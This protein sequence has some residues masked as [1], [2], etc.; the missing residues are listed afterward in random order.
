[1]LKIEDV[2]IKFD[3]KIILSQANFYANDSTLTI[4]K[5]QSGIGKSTFLKALM[6]EYNCQY[7]YGN[8]N[9]SLL[10]T[11]EKDQ[12]IY[13]K[14]SFVQQIPL[15]LQ[16]MTIKEH[17]S[18]LE[19]MKKKRNEE[20]EQKLNILKLLNKYP[21][22]LS[23][24]EKTKVAIYLGI[25]KEPDILILDEPTASLDVDS[26]N[27][28]I[29]LLKDYAHS[30]HIV[31]ATSHDNKLVKNADIIY[32][33]KDTKL[34][35]SSDIEFKPKDIVLL[36]E[37]KPYFNIKQGH[38]FFRIS[39]LIFI[40]ISMIISIYGFHILT[41]YNQ[42][43][44]N[45]LNSMSSLDILVYKQKYQ[46]DHYSYEGFEYPF[47]E[48][49]TQSLQTLKN[50][51]H[52]SWHYDCAYYNMTIYDNYIDLKN[53]ADNP[54]KV[55]LYINNHSFFEDKDI[56]YYSLHSYNDEIDYSNQLE[57]NFNTK[58][59][60]LTWDLYHS[61]NEN[62]VFD[63]TKDTLSLKFILLIPT[64]NASNISEMIINEESYVKVNHINSTVK[65]IT[66]PIAGILKEDSYLYNVEPGQA[67][68]IANS[69]L[70]KYIEEY[71]AIY[72]RTAYYTLDNNI[73]KIY[74]DEVPNNISSNHIYQ[75]IVESPWQPNSYIVTVDSIENVEEVAQELK[76][77]GFCVV[78]E[79]VDS[80]AFQVLN[81]DNQ[82]IL[83]TFMIVIFVIIYAFYI[84]LKLLI[85][86][87][88]DEDR[89]YL[90]NL[91]FN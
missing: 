8:I 90:K 34:I 70:E 38:S 57:Y 5:G 89:D 58:G 87:E 53:E 41:G 81:K 7:Y 66:V 72:P 68:Y 59:L 49:E 30:G 69:V 39:M 28:I 79:Y 36:K 10:N 55:S 20:L 54:S 71:K 25:I 76:D 62:I 16:S 6:F 2:S 18:M 4:I 78:N 91:G 80:D 63:E 43:Y 86:K 11:K 15:F 50:V 31:I 85:M 19:K 14:I 1:M 46:N 73:E 51:S 24:G 82:I 75:H 21:K 33:I 44:Q 3:H 45:I 88:E 56:G 84:Y 64:Y 27:I 37:K 13:E 35:S 48:R 61:L 29:D 67:L 83:I 9:L 47:T 74:Y 26:A 32:Q 17:V 60:F 77:M 42:S 12:F 52:I 23:S 65:E 40:G 22:E